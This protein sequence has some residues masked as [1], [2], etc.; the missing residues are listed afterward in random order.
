MKNVNSDANTMSYKGYTVSMVFDVEDKIIVGRVLNVDDIIS[1]HAE[2][3][4][5]V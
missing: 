1:F 2:S 4:V 3:R 5:G